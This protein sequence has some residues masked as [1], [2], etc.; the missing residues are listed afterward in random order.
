MFIILLG[1]RQMKTILKP[2]P[3]FR[4]FIS[5]ILIL[6]SLV[7]DIALLSNVHYLQFYFNIHDLCFYK[8]NPDFFQF[9]VLDIL[10][11]SFVYILRYILMLHN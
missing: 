9:V 1:K 2:N 11:D 8:P 3:P 7:N 4:P 5:C 6:K 10:H